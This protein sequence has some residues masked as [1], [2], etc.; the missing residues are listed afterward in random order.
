VVTTDDQPPVRERATDHSTRTLVA[1]ADAMRE[2][3]VRAAERGS[4]PPLDELTG[5][6]LEQLPTATWA[7]VT[8]LRGGH[9]ATEAATHDEARRADALQY[10]I[11]SGPCVD[12]VLNESIYR[13]GDV[14]S[15]DRWR[16]WGRRAHEATGVL[17]VLAYRLMLL[18]DSGSI[19]GLNVYSD[20]RDAFD[21]SS[22]GTGLLLATHGSLLVTA[23]VARDHADN[24]TLA[25]ESNREIGVAMGILMHQHRLSR[26]QAFD[27][28]RVASQDSNRKLGDI[29]TEVA[30]TGILSVGRWATMLAGGGERRVAT[31]RSSDEGA[32]AR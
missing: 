17:S 18:D 22:V 9:F 3:A 15:D 24:L 32:R 23:L 21:D 31:R 19:A 1:L 14:T 26:E 6:T 13:T 27:V 5:A 29:A 4:A 12:A 16:E 20:Q 28:L 2:V 11:G 7:S 8:V 25:L 30:D 10:E